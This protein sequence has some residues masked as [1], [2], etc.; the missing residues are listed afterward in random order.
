MTYVSMF[1]SSLTNDQSPLHTRDWEPTTSTLHALSLV[2]KVEPVQVFFTLRLRDQWSM[3]MQDGYKVYIDSYMASNGSCFMVTWI[4]FWNHLLEVGVTQNQEITTLRMFTNADLF[5]IIM[6]LRARMNRNSLI[7][8][9]FGWGRGH[10]W[11]HTTLENPWPYYMILEVVSRLR[12]DTFCWA[13]TFAWSQLLARVWSGFEFGWVPYR[14]KLWSLFKGPAWIKCP[15]VMSMTRC[16][17]DKVE[18]HSLCDDCFIQ[19][20]MSNNRINI[21]NQQLS[22]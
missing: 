5:Y 22:W 4:I 15:F 13:L 17:P 6:V 21:L 3:W 1:G 20:K 14:W 2:E 18:F 19:N 16:P 11:L 12:L 8:I 9:T 7:E 10:I